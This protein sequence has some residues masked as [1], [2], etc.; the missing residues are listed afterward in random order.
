MGKR[1]GGVEGMRTFALPGVTAGGGSAASSSLTVRGAGGAGGVFRLLGLR[2][3]SSG[4]GAASAGDDELEEEGEE[5]AE[6]AEPRWPCGCVCGAPVSA[7]GAGFAA[8][9]EVGCADRFT[10]ASPRA[11]LPSLSAFSAFASPASSSGPSLRFCRTDALGDAKEGEST[12][13]MGE[14]APLVT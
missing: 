4:A 12:P 11:F 14:G 1:P 7:A 6:A 13:R 2:V 8:G 5:G 10:S 3:R 9:I